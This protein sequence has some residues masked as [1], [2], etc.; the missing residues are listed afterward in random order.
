MPG[1]IINLL[2][3]K[4]EVRHQVLYRYPPTQR[5]LDEADDLVR[6]F[7]ECCRST[8]RD[9]I[10]GGN[11]ES[12]FTFSLA[13]HGPSSVT[14]NQ[15]RVH[16][17]WRRKRVFTGLVNRLKSLPEVERVG[18]RSVAHS[19]EGMREAARVLGFQEAADNDFIWSRSRSA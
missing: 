15:V 1:A 17:L 9:L 3:Q 19:A 10:F 7:V 5:E 6:E 14:I 2:R 12:A 16:K 18:I 13:F 11:P 4:H 8:G